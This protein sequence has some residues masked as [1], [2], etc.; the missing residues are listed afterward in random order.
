[1]A[2]F[3]QFAGSGFFVIVGVILG[4]LL[5]YWRDN[6]KEKT[7]KKKYFQLFISDLDSLTKKI[8]YIMNGIYS[9]TQRGRRIA[10]RD[11]FFGQFNFDELTR[12]YDMNYE[13]LYYFNENAVMKVNNVYFHIKSAKDYCEKKEDPKNCYN[14]LDLAIKGIDAAKKELKDS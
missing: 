14:E 7:A 11:V 1:M 8:D 3:I 6:Q 10:N 9:E 13:R 5:N 12:F 2:D 4:F